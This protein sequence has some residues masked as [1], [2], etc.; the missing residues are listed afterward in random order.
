MLSQLR[1]QN[2]AYTVKPSGNSDDL[3]GDKLSVF[4]SSSS[5]SIL[6]SFHF[7]LSV[8]FSLPCPALSNISYVFMYQ[9]RGLEAL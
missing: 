1:D 9:R 6:F 5:F 2:Q 4:F 7:F 8:P 3:H